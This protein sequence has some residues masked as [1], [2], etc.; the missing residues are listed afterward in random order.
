MNHFAVGSTLA[1]LCM[2]ALSPFC[3]AQTQADESAIRALIDA[4]AAAWNRGN[5]SAAASVY[6]DNAN[7]IAG[8]HRLHV[9]RAAI[10]ELHAEALGQAEPLLHLHPQET[11]RIYFL[12]PDIAIAD[13]ESRWFAHGQDLSSAAAEPVSKVNI[14]VVIEKEERGWRVVA[15][16]P[17]T[18]PVE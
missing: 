14:F 4:H 1:S 2:F 9:G 5:V 11:L 3:L 18:L 16:R 12:R 13:V 15:Q 10:D 7:V 6:S 8:N 17:T